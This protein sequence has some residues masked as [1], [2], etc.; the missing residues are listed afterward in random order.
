MWNRRRIFKRVCDC[1]YVVFLGTGFRDW[2]RWSALRQ[3]FSDGDEGGDF[4]PNLAAVQLS[5]IR[6]DGA[7]VHRIRDIAGQSIGAS[8]YVVLAKL[9]RLSYIWLMIWLFA[10]FPA[11]FELSFV[12]NG[13]GH[14]LQSKCHSL[15][16]STLCQRCA[17]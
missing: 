14:F 12:V 13:N 3:A 10:H 11:G 16:T 9:R 5:R 8:L 1:K 17:M 15:K 4:I 2:I 6:S 7:R